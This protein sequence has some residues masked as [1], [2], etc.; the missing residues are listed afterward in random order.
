MPLP[1][2]GVVTMAAGTQFLANGSNE[3]VGALSGAGTI[4]LGSS[5]AGAAFTFGDASNQTFSGLIIGNGSQG[6]VIYQGGG[7]A[8]LSGVN[9]FSGSISINGQGGGG[10]LVVAA[11]SGL[12]NSSNPVTID[13]AN[14]LGASASFSSSRSIT[15]G[16]NGGVLDVIGSNTVLTL[17]G[18]LT[19]Q[20]TLTVNNP[21]GAIGA[22]G[23]LVL[24]NSNNSFD[25][26][27]GAVV[28]SFGTLSVNSPA[29]LGT[30]PIAFTGYHDGSTLEFAGSGTYANSMTFPAAGQGRVW[31][32][33]DGNNVTFSGVLAPSP[34]VAAD[35]VEV[36]KTGLG[37]LTLACS[38]A[39]SG[40]LGYLYIDQGGVVFS[41]SAYASLYPNDSPFG[42]SSGA[43][44]T[45]SAVLR[46]NWPMPNWA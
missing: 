24:T 33:T 32:N 7:I 3:T 45:V 12:G 13:Y 43:F 21:S 35:T 14:M 36:H 34:A 23:T 20:G 4:N 17:T 28:F 19:S 10:E 25:P 26:V 39:G 42:G 37:T 6:Q 9:T 31:F 2:S 44:T 22:G 5:S 8:T 38:Q 46:C 27:A 18:P 11:D 30:A 29:C 1:Q 41:T 15:I 40:K 16:P